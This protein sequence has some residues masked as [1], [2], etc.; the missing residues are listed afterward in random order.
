MA[1]RMDRA[2][3]R[4]LRAQGWTLDQLGARYGVSRPRVSFVCRGVICPVNHNSRA[5]RALADLNIGAARARRAA[6]WRLYALGQEPKVIAFNLGLHVGT[7]YSHLAP[8]ASPLAQRLRQSGGAANS[9][10]AACR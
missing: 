7:V 6:I 3:C 8:I 4:A 2:E 9:E 1:G 10:A 5:G